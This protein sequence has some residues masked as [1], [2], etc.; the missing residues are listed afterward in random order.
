MVV[1]GGGEWGGGES[2]TGRDRYE[3]LQSLFNP[4]RK[5]FFFFPRMF[6]SSYRKRSNLIHIVHAVAADQ[7]PQNGEKGMKTTN[8]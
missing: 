6:L 8:V 5:D 1:G 2:P 4:K 3:R 7:D